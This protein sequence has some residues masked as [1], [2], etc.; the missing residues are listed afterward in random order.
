MSAN[1]SGFVNDAEE[2]PIIFESPKSMS[3]E[4]E[5][6]EGG[7]KREQEGSNA[8]SQQKS[9]D[10]VTKSDEEKEE[11]EIRMRNLKRARKLYGPS[12]EP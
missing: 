3:P 11:V 9:E 7:S 5:K 8:G 1:D 6:A 10:S 2:E 12:G 4:P